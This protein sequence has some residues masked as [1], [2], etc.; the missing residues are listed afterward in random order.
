MLYTTLKIQNFSLSTMPMFS[1]FP[2]ES[3]VGIAINMTIFTHIIIKQVRE[4]ISSYRVFLSIER[5]T[6]T[7]AVGMGSSI[8]LRALIRNL[9]HKGGLKFQIR[10]I[11]QEW[12]AEG[13]QQV[14]TNMNFAL[15]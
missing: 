4:K 3:F 8:L 2:V 1:P 12:Q 10:S 5:K 9:L 13:K 14:E 7:S 6:V 15:I 11:L